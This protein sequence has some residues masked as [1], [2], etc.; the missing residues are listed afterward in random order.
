M[1]TGP[2][3]TA[4]TNSSSNTFLL[5]EARTLFRRL[6]NLDK[7]HVNEVP[8]VVM[9]KGLQVVHNVR[10]NELAQL[11]IGLLDGIVIEEVSQDGQLGH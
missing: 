8:N 2:L 5:V 6:L 9:V 10:L 4:E 3:S 11:V 7:H 1:W